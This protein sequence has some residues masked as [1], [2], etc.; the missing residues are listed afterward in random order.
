MLDLPLAVPWAIESLCLN[1]SLTPAAW[2]LPTKGAEELPTYDTIIIHKNNIIENTM[3]IT[4][5]M[6]WDAAIRDIFINKHLH[7]IL[8]AVP[9]KFYKVPMLERW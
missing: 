7:A 2:L 5:Q 8:L 3:K 1:S 4:M 6:C 9:Q